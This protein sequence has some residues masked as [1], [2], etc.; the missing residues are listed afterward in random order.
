MKK[1]MTGKWCVR[2]AVGLA[3]MMVS[4]VMPI[5]DVRGA[6]PYE[7]IASGSEWEVLKIVNRERLS[8]GE[9]AVAMFRD[10]QKAAGTRAL[11]V[12][13]YFS[14]TR[15]DGTSCFSVLGEYDVPYWSAGENIAAGQRDASHVMECWMNSQ[16]HRQNILNP[17]YDHIGVGYCS[18]GSY[19][20]N[21]V[22]IFI[23]G[24]SVQ[25]VTLGGKQ[26]VCYPVGTTIENMNRYLIVKCSDHGTGYVPVISEMCSGY[27]KDKA[28]SQTVTIR[29]QGKS[30][31][32]KVVI[33]SDA[34]N[35][36]NQAPAKV[37]G[38][39][40]KRT[41]TKT[42]SLLFRKADADGYEVY[43]AT[44]RNG[45]Y[46][47]VKTLSGQKKCSCQIKGLSAKRTYYFKVRAY[48]KNGK[49]KLYGKF[50][51]VKSA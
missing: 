1:K 7:K 2:A 30:V 15:P 35:A 29:Y 17:N 20:K 40:A 5:R 8:D 3:A 14:H 13:S 18:G 21:W 48:K 43:M 34:D 9:E 37:T 27:R 38:L 26:G 23:G 41:Q 33:G 36:A 19:G 42:V 49:T 11:E 25:S 50:S 46:K 47:K 32:M 22:Q 28:G 39:K 6:E 16:G 24:C 12:K 10:L 4:L 44:S 45:K 51:T 31:K